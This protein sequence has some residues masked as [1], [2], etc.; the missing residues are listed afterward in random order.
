LA[1]EGSKVKAARTKPK[2]ID[3]YISSFPSGVQEM[4]EQIRRTIRKAAPGA[5]ETISYQ[6]PAFRLE[7]IL[8]Y[9]AA[10]KNHISLFPQTT[11]IAKFKRQL[12]RYE[13][14]KGTVRFPIDKP[15]PLNLIG[16]IVKFRVKENLK[17]V[18]AKRNSKSR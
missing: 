15:L 17:R 8:V 5:E 12:S 16:K 7:G 2:G 4:L 13:G 1:G 18:A 10:F 3:Q 14:A 11:A 9:F 6:M